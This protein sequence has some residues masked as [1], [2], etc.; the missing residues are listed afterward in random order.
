M[1]RICDDW[2]DCAEAFKDL[3]RECWNKQGET[4]RLSD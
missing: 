2:D 3:M 1:E 4:E